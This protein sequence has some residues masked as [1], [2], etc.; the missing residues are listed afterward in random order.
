MVL[1]QFGFAF[2]YVISEATLKH[3]MDHY[4]LVVY[5]NAVG[6]VVI[7]P[8][9][10]WLER[11]TRPKL[12]T[13]IFLKLVALA[14][15]EPV[16]DQNLYYVGSKLTSASFAAALYNILPAITFLTALLLRMEKVNLKRRHSRAKVI[17][18]VITFGGAVLLILYKGPIVSLLWSKGR[19]HHGAAGAVLRKGG[20]GGNFFRGTLM[21]LA[22][23]MAWSA[24]LIVQSKT[25]ERYPA[26]LSLSS[27]MCA[28]GVILNTIIALLAKR[29][30][31]HPW[32]IGWDMRLFT[33]IYNVSYSS[34]IKLIL[35]SFFQ[36]KHTLY[37]HAGHHLYQVPYYVQGMI[38]KEGVQFLLLPSILYA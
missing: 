34:L 26:E 5:R 33:A 24:F 6:A 4:V 35:H 32:R 37:I 36:L 3:G 19:T 30:S 21:L 12:T 29:G 28:L 38:I 18:S 22:S 23:C 9:A 16:M 27:W 20:G 1:L 2:S 17:G 11:K 31:T 13:P 8:F 15:L 25:L 14:L 10:F 7:T